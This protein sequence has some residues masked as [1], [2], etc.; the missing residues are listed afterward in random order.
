LLSMCMQFGLI[1]VTNTALFLIS[2]R[3]LL[4]DLATQGNLPQWT[5]VET[6]FGHRRPTHPELNLF[7]VA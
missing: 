6:H 1:K 7:S 3:P 5:Q 4:T 2:A